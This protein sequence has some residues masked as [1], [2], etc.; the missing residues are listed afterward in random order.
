[1]GRRQ[2]AIVDGAVQEVDAPPRHDVGSY[3][4]GVDGILDEYRVFLGEDI[5]DIAQ[6]ALG[7]ITDEHLAGI[8]FNAFTGITAAHGLPE[9]GIPLLFPIP[10]EGF[11]PTHFATAFC[12]ASTTTGA[13]GR[14][15][16]PIPRLITSFPGFWALYSPTFWATSENR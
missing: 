11:R 15:T 9:K 13:R 7:P 12:M 10:P 6:I 8:Q 5:Q 14:V 4:G 1:M 3:I 16:S 2:K